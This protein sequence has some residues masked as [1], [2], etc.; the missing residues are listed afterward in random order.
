[1]NLVLKCSPQ[2][3]LILGSS[4]DI[5]R[6]LILDEIKKRCKL[7][8]YSFRINF[9]KLVISKNEINRLKKQILKI[10]PNFIFYLSSPKI[11]HGEKKNKML[12]KYY[13]IM[14]VHYFK[15]ILKIIHDNKI[16]TKIFY[17]S[18]I[19]LNNKNKYKRLECYLMAKAKA[20]EICESKR[21]RKLVTFFRI[22][23]LISRSNYNMLGFYEG[24]NLKIVDKYLDK[25]FK[26]ATY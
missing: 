23:Q 21:N 1:M 13:K 15:N 9:N 6:R 24:Q 26:K 2:K 16:Q 18:T 25:F 5:A 22:P 8:F 17:P 19:Y 3:I 10:K 4:S 7:F 20:E 12:F 14:Y 11:Y